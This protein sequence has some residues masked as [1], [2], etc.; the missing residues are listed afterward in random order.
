VEMLSSAVP[1]TCRKATLLSLL[2]EGIEV[3]RRHDRTNYLGGRGCSEKAEMD[4]N[5]G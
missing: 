5:C 3:I 2:K 4:Q 1:E